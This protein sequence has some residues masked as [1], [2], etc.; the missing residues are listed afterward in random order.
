MTIAS[1]STFIDVVKKL[2][3]DKN[4]FYAFRGHSSTEYDLFPSVFRKLG[5]LK[6]EDFLFKELVSHNPEEF[7]DCHYAIEYLVKMQHYGLPTRLLDLTTNP[8]IALFFAVSENF[9]DMGE[10]IFFRIPKKE[11][12]YYDSDNVSVLSNV[13]KMDIAFNYSKYEKTDDFDQR[14]KR[15]NNQ[16]HINLLHHQIGFEKPH[17]QK[18]IHPD[19]IDQVICV[20]PK[21]NNPRI[22]NQ[23]G[24]F[25]L[26]GCGISKKDI[27]DINHEWMVFKNDEEKIILKNKKKIL[28]ELELFGITNSYVYPE[29]DKYSKKLVADLF[30]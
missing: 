19:G 9:N 29:M 18:M 16:E 13:A 25:L 6:K 12:K 23:A 5:I 2:D 30:E 4:Y 14:R 17:F 21:L 20:K 10:V 28:K 26:F 1:I 11:V 3:Q 7:R 15:F 24:L 22:I 27:P 8:L